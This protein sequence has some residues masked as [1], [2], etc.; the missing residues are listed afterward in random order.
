MYLITI[1]TEKPGESPLK[2][3]TESRHLA[4]SC[5]YLCEENE[6]ECEVVREVKLQPVKFR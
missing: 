6:L 2:L 5:S 1:K 4:K 3:Q